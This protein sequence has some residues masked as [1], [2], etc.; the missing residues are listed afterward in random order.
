MSIRI[1]ELAKRHNMEAKD[2][3]ALLQGYRGGGPGA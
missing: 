3:L 1:H 2:M